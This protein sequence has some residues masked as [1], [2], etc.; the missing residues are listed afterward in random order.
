MEINRLLLPC[1]HI[2]AN[3][4]LERFDIVLAT[5]EQIILLVESEG[6]NAENHN[7]IEHVM[8][9]IN[10]VENIQETSVKT[11][12]PGQPKIQ[13]PKESIEELLELKFSAR[14]IAKIYNVSDKTIYRR[15]KEYG[16]SVR[17]SYSIL[18]DTELQEVMLGILAD[19]PFTGYKRMLGFLS[20]KGHKVQTARVQLCMRVVD[21]FGVQARTV[22]NRAINRRLYFVRYA[23]DRWHL[24]TNMKLTR[25]YKIIIRSAIDGCTRLCVYLTVGTDNRS[26]SNLKSFMD[27]VSEWGP[28]K[29]IRCDKGGENYGIA[30]FMLSLRG[31]DSKAVLAGRS[32]HN[33][34]IERF[35]VDVY[36]ESQYFLA[37]FASMEQDGILDI[38]NP[39]HL[40]VLHYV[41][42]P[43]M[44]HSYDQFRNGWNNH[45]ISTE[46]SRSPLQLMILKRHPD[47]PENVTQETLNQ[48]FSVCMTYQ[49]GN[50]DQYDSVRNP[51][52]V[53]HNLSEIQIERLRLIDTMATSNNHG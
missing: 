8:D 3:G 40:F 44:Q 27:G 34:R 39:V 29:A 47:F 2:I 14:C 33:Q 25:R 50:T 24:D 22:L 26:S 53:L 23:M 5:L 35:W 4:D 11:R 36:R 17:D 12:L 30:R 19:H 32:V 20:A 42:V 1:E 6:E 15:L 52:P 51:S 46:N 43:R 9:L 37:I 45:K 31:I 13:I 21:P 10:T 49:D 18:S 48:L 41:F 16:M 28:P 7:L 38:D